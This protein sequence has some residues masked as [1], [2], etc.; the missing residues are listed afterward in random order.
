MKVALVNW[1]RQCRKIVTDRSFWII[2]AML[3]MI[4]LLHYLTPQ[5]GPL[6]PEVNT[7]LSRH[8]VERII[9]TLPVAAATFA[10]GRAGGLVT[11]SLALLIMLPRAI[12]L[13]H[14]PIDAVI[15]TGATSA[16]SSS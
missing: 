4:T 3:A 2:A 12:W 7:I 14:Y 15:E 1:K 5:I 8:A 9:F 16:V 10:F 6:S 13:S 11:L